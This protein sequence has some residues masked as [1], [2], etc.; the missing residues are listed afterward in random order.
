VLQDAN[1]LNMTYAAKPCKIEV[2][3]LD[4][5]C[6]ETETASSDGESLIRFVPTLDL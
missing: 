6:V 1:F 3:Q 4:S 5:R 2:V